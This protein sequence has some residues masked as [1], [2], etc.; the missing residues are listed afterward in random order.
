[1]DSPHATVLLVDD[2]PDLINIHSTYLKLLGFTSLQA[3]DGKSAIA[4]LDEH[5][6]D[7]DIILSDVVMP[8]MSGYEFCRAVKDKEETKDIPF[9][10]VSSHTTLEEKLK[11]YAVGGDDYI[12]KPIA[13][14][15]LSLKIN[16]LLDARNKSKQ[17]NERL[18]ETHNAAMQAM[19][20]S[21]DLGQVLEFYKNSLNAKSFEELAEFLFEVTESYGLNATLQIITPEKTFCLTAKG[22]ASPLESNVI[23]LSRSKGR[24]FDFGTRTV[25]NYEDFS[26]LVKNMPVDDPERYG[27]FKDTLGSLCNA[28][29]AR[30]KLLM[31][32]S[33]ASKNEE[34]V[35]TVKETLEEVE[36][37]FR[38]T[39]LGNVAAIEKLSDELEEAMLTKLGLTEQQEDSIREIVKACLENTN[40]VY[41]ESLT[42]H[43][44]FENMNEQLRGMLGIK[45]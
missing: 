38:K 13:P 11:G 37:I 27:M 34:I 31:V 21:S 1:M 8:E 17:L 26:L 40:K 29:E 33:V 14:E 32:N 45:V 28:I 10:F 9:L 3:E 24:F 42:L 5:P 16:A 25:I 18:A 35:D 23:E 30:V 22:V 41:E 19:T 15:E 36:D 4:V 20:Y 2:D 6:T 12:T 44:M 39:Q 43:N 7:V